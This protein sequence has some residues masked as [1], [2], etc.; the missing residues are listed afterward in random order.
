MDMAYKVT[1]L[2]LLALVTTAGSTQPRNV[3]ARTGLLNVCMDA[4]HH[5]A[6][7]GPEDNLYGQ[8][9]PW[10]KNAC[11]TA[12]TSQYNTSRL[13]NFN[14]EHCGRM[15]PACKHHFIRDTCLYES[16]PNLGPD[17]VNQSWRKER[18]LNVPLCKEDC[19]RW[20]EDC[21]TSYTCK[22][23]WQ[24]GWNWTSGINECPAGALCHTFESYFPTPAALCEGLWSHSYKVSDYSRGSG[25]CIQMWFDSAQGNPNEEV[26]RFY[27]AAMKAEAPSRG[28]LGP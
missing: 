2:L 11:C 28:I 7:P 5:K 22:S 17:P 6:H 21:R 20:W 26:A 10:R 27:A 1:Q 12:N 4:K 8:C 13:Y 25:R 19:E 3:W 9:S 23:N 14:W 16:S 24:K 15:E 18:I